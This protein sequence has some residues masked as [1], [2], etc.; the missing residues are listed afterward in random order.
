VSWQVKVHTFLMMETPTVRFRLHGGSLLPSC[1]VF[2]SESTIRVC[3]LPFTF[4]VVR[5]CSYSFIVRFVCWC[6]QPSQGGGGKF[7]SVMDCQGA[8]ELAGRGLLTVRGTSPLSSWVHP[9]ICDIVIRSL[10][11]SNSYHGCRIHIV[12]VK[13]APWKLSN[14]LRCY[15]ISVMVV[16]VA[17]KIGSDLPMAMKIRFKTNNIDD[18]L[19][20]TILLQL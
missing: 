16:V 12:V 8:G 11:L 19:R 13:S 2:D 7:S 14:P 3:H 15:Q 20:G 18:E 1:C 4:V 10:S 17:S 9:S 6:H 5:L